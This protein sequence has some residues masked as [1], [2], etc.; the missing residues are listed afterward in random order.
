MDPGDNSEPSD[1]PDAWDRP[2]AAHHLGR[3][4]RGEHEDHLQSRSCHHWTRTQ[5]YSLEVSLQT[6]LDSKLVQYGS[7][8]INILNALFPAL[9]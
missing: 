9:A 2:A 1:G 3:D 7:N 5:R 4:R 6:W 8:P